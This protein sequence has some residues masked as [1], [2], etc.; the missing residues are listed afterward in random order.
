MPN[1]PPCLAL[2]VL[3]TLVSACAAEPAKPAAPP[4]EV[5]S[6]PP[7]HHH[8]LH[9]PP[10][11]PQVSVELG[12]KKVAITLADVPHGGG[13][14]RLASVWKAA[15]PDDDLMTLNVDLFGSDGFHP[16]ARPA[17]ARL[18]TGA[19]IGTAQIEVAT[20]DVS[21]DDG[22]TLPGCYR[23]KGVVRIVGERAH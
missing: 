12:E 17:C 5:A 18:L 6:A 23:V 20:H 8:E 4:P 14:A 10:A 13:S 1:L 21:F 16:A 15:F 11:G 22:V 19:E 2:T 7:E 9:L 3:L